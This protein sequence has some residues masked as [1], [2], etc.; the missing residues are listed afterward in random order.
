MKRIKQITVILVT[1]TMCV[2]MTLPVNA[3]YSFSL[4]G[5]DESYFVEVLEHVNATVADSRGLTQIS[6]YNNQGGMAVAD[7]L[8]YKVAVSETDSASSGPY[9][10]NTLVYDSLPKKKQ[11]EVITAFRDAVNAR[12]FSVDAQQKI[13]NALNEVDNAYVSSIVNNLFDGSGTASN[14]LIL[15]MDNMDKIQIV[16]GI[17]SG[18]LLLGFIFSIIL[19]LCYINIPALQTLAPPEKRTIFSKVARAAVVEKYSAQSDGLIFY[20]KH[21]F[22]SIIVFMIVF[23]LLFSGKFSQV[24]LFFVEVFV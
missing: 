12:P 5:T 7:T 4:N 2:I 14:M 20:F 9:V 1:L 24:L 15:L 8:F 23:Y 16:L 3:I 21:K 10:F 22:I 17:C 11:K 19:D 18:L 6:G 13:Y